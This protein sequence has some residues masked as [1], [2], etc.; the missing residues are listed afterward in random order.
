VDD[1][2][3]GLPEADAELGAR[4]GQE[5]V[6]LVF[7]SEHERSGQDELDVKERMGGH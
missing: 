2:A 4:R 1:A 5:V 6:H 3:A 7:I